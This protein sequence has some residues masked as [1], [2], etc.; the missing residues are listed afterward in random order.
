MIIVIFLCLFS[1][2]IPVCN[3]SIEIVG[4]IFSIVLEIHDSYQDI[5]NTPIWIPM[6]SAC[7][8]SVNRQKKTTMKAH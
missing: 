8:I 1:F 4:K 6:T 5:W 2:L 3:V 7:H